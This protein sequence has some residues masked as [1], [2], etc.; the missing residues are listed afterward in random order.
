MIS[1]AYPL[2]IAAFAL[3][4][5]CMHLHD[6]AHGSST[7]CEPLYLTLMASVLFLQSGAWALS[8]Y[9]QFKPDIEISL[10]VGVSS[11]V[12]LLSWMGIT[13]LLITEGHHIFAG[14]FIASFLVGAYYATEIWQDAWRSLQSHWG[15]QQQWGEPPP[16]SE[17]P[18]SE[19]THLLMHPAESRA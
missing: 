8:Q 3:A 11:M 15:E 18:P 6:L 5:L 9:K 7:T 2:L 19:H 14:V 17:P 16:W 1:V 4:L 12:I 10:W 13:R